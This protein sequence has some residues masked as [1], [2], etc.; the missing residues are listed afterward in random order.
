[1][2]NTGET[3]GIRNIAGATDRK[4]RQQMGRVTQCR[5]HKFVLM[6]G[7]TK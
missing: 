3:L 6:K 2:I 5:R 1:M 7:T 4:T